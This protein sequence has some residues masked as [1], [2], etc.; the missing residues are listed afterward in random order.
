MAAAPLLVRAFDGED[1]DEVPV[2][3]VIKAPPP[4]IFSP[5]AKA[6]AKVAIVRCREY[7]AEF[8]RDWPMP[9]TSWA[10]S[11]GW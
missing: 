6:N 11:A 2:K 3:R 1:G 10:A 9:L 8:Q 7:G 4:P 5:T